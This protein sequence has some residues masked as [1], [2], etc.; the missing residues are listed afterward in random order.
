MAST[1]AGVRI[2]AVRAL[3]NINDPQAIPPL[4]AAL[5]DTS[6]IVEYWAEHGLERLGVGMVFFNP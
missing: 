3:S 1:D 5:N 4:L 6:R 2:E